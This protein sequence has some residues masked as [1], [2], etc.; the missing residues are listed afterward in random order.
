MTLVVL[1]FQLPHQV[2]TELHYTSRSAAAYVGGLLAYA[3][4]YDSSRCRSQRLTRPGRTGGLLTLGTKPSGQTH[5]K[6]NLS[7]T[8]DPEP[9]LHRLTRMTY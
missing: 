7:N 1:R 5:C 3:D 2:P 9:R 6:L 4:S 8:Q